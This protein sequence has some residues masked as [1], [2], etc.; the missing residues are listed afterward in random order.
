MRRARL[1]LAS[2]VPTRR[3]LELALEQPDVLEALDALRLGNADPSPAAALA[4]HLVRAVLVGDASFETS[5]KKETSESEDI[6][7]AVLG[8]AF[9]TLDSKP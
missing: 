6:A 7:A 5:E 8:D 4:C 9:F 2:V 1:E 3:A